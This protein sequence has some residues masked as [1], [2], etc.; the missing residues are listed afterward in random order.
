MERC[1]KARSVAD[2]TL[3]GGARRKMIWAWTWCG[4]GARV[5]VVNLNASQSLYGGAGTG[6]CSAA[7]GRRYRRRAFGAPEP[8]R[9]ASELGRGAFVPV[10]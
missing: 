8:R 4:S 1:R 6:A 10:A 2:T 3:T 9:T 5:G 7:D